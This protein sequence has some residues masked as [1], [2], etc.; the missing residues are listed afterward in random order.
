MSAPMVPAPMTCTR[1]DAG[2]LLGRL[3]LQQL[4][5]AEHAAQIARLLR[6][7]QRREDARLGGLHRL[8]VAAVALEQ[9]DEPVGRRI[10]ILARL[11]AR[12]P[13][14]IR[15]GEQ[16]RGPA[17]WRAAAWTKPAGFDLRFRSTAL[18][19]AQRSAPRCR[20]ACRRGPCR[21]PP[22]R[23]HL[24]GQHGLHGGRAPACANRAR[25]AVEAG[26]DAELHF[27]EAEPGALIAR[28][29]A[30]VAGERQLEPAAEAEAVDGAD[31]RHRQP[32]DA[33]EQR[34]APGAASR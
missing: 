9:V 4:R 11:L 28:R 24:A 23:Q 33:V 7:H 34:R 8:V 14:R 32:L 17:T 15:V 30:V 2:E 10:V 20:R 18:R 27:G 19:A 16:S 3:A 22:G 26:E 5:Q 29:D 12:P 13:L 6:H 31:D 21:A 1:W 25:R